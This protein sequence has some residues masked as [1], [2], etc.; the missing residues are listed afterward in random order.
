MI[1]DF[2][3]WLG[4]NFFISIFQTQNIFVGPNFKIFYHENSSF[5][6]LFQMFLGCHI[7]IFQMYWGVSWLF[8]MTSG[9]TWPMFLE[10][11]GGSQTISNDFRSN[12]TNVSR[13]FWGVPDYFQWLPEQVDQCFASVWGG[14]Q[15]I[16]NGFWSNYINASRV[17]WRAPRLLLATS[18]VNTLMSLKCS[19]SWGTSLTHPFYF[20]KQFSYILHKWETHPWKYHKFTL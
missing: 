17:F 16:S 11:F 15:T 8:L 12:L 9:A 18:E 7:N 13:V 2:Q 6:V 10:C 20:C 3:I 5:R 14:P 1:E 19:G 4:R